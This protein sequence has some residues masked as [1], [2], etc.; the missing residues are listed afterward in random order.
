MA[1]AASSVSV[2]TC[3]LPSVRE[4]PPAGESVRAVR[5]VELLRHASLEFLEGRELSGLVVIPSP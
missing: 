1:Y 4:A 5:T 2:V 3:P